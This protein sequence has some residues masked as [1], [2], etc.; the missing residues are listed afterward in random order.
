MCQYSAAA[1]GLPRDWHLVHLGQFA[2][3]G[4]GLVMTEASAVL[5]EGRLSP[6]D[7]GLW[8]DAQAQAWAP[9][10]RF[11]QEHGSRAGIQLVHAGRKASAAPPWEG[12][13]HVPPADGGWPTVAPSAIAFGSLPAPT[14]LDAAGIARVIDAF[15]AAAARALQAGFDVVELHAAH[16]YLLHEFLS[17]ISNT[18]TDAYGGDFD[19]RTRLLREVSRAVREVWPDDRPLFVRVSATDWIE[20]GWDGDAT[21]ALARLLADDGVDLLDCSTGGVVRDAVIPT[22]P[23]YQ[24]AYAARVRAET[25]MPTAAVGLITDPHDAE[26]VLAEGAA[27]AVMLGRAVLREPHWPLLAAAELGVDVTWPRQYDGAKPAYDARPAGR[28]TLEE[29]Q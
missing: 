29:V 17:P 15:R 4:A 20:G 25:G 24:V 19:G 14:A 28:E 21:V 27:D 7:T 16:G 18:R 8:D 2:V 9:V 3:G 26:A 12:Q 6:A 10:V 11:L 1:D 23:R 5:P 22:G 13:V